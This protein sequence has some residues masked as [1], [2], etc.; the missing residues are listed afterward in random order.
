[1][2]GAE[3]EPGNVLPAHVAHLDESG[4]Q[5]VEEGLEVDHAGG[6][7]AETLDDLRAHRHGPDIQGYIA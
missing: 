1:M 2:L 5:A 4:F 6:E 3:P 7:D